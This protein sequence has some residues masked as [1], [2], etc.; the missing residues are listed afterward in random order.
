[1]VADTGHLPVQA[2]RPHE[3]RA[4]DL[5]VLDVV[6]LHASG[7]GVAQDHVVFAEARKIAEAHDLPVQA[8]V[9]EERG[10][11]DVVGDVINLEAAGIGIAQQHVGGVVAEK[12]AER[13]E[14]PIGADL[15]QGVGG[16]DRVVADVVDPVLTRH[17]G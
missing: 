9:A 12:A 13:D 5:V 15:T 1:M 2:D 10:A 17:A 3:G 8:D 6:D 4:G 14:A 7:A 11:G 16:H